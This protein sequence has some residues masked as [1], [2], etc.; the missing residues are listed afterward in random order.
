VPAHLVGATPSDRVH[1]L[2]VTDLGL[3]ASSSE[4]TQLS[5]FMLN[6]CLR[7]R[8]YRLVAPDRITG[9]YHSVT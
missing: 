6:H 4:F 7:G 8:V 9:V 1:H 3:S 2:S 5:L